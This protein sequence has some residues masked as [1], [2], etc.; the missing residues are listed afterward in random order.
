[1]CATCFTCLHLPSYCYSFLFKIDLFVLCLLFVHLTLLSSLL[2]LGI[3]YYSDVSLQSSYDTAL[4]ASIAHELSQK[5]FDKYIGPAL[6]V[7]DFKHKFEREG[8]RVTWEEAR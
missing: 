4:D 7:N 2:H 3:P 6:T 8:L 1:M 5:S